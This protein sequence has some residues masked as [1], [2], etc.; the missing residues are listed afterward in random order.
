MPAPIK[1][2]T[3]ILDAAYDHAAKLHTAALKGSSRSA[4]K[5]HKEIIALIPQGFYRHYKG[6]V[7]YVLGI[8]RER[9]KEGREIYYVLTAPCI[10]G[11]TQP[12][13]RWKLIWSTGK[14]GS[15]WFFPAKKGKKQVPRFVK[16]QGVTLAEVGRTL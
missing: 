12:I 14:I 2:S 1:D 13:V 7:Y 10:E 3:S 9:R 4:R 5:A 16:V 15:V 8:E 6:D 11:N